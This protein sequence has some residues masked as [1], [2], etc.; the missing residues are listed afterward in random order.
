[1]HCVNTQGFFRPAPKPLNHAFSAKFVDL[2]HTTGF[3]RLSNAEGLSFADD[4]IQF[5][6]ILSGAHNTAQV[7]HAVDALC[8]T[9]EGPPH[10]ALM[11]C[12]DSVED[13][14]AAYKRGAAVNAYDEDLPYVTCAYVYPTAEDEKF[15]HW[16]KSLKDS[17]C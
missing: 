4:F 11:D 9:E 1:M 8:V 7:E 10:T 3:N 13:L 2:I 15:A 12:S 14:K 17:D 16:W 6:E 5:G